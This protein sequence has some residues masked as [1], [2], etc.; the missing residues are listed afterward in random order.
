MN[1]MT[2]IAMSTILL[3]AAVLG[4]LLVIA[5][6]LKM[7]R[8]RFEVPFSMLWQ[9]VLKEKEA[10]SLWRHL[11][12]LLS[13][14][15]LVAMVAMLLF[16][17][18]DPM[19]GGPSES[20]R[21]VI[22]IIDSS[23]SMKTMDE[24]VDETDTTRL[25]AAKRKANEVLDSMGADDSVMIVR[26]DGRSTPMGRFQTDIPKLKRLVGQINATDT[27]AD[28]RSTLSTA[29]D[30]LRWRQNPV[31]IL[32]GD[33]AYPEE[34]LGSVVWENSQKK[35]TEAPAKEKAA[36]SGFE[37]QRLAIVDLSGIE[38]HY[39]PVGQHAENAGIVAFNVRRYISN[40]LNYEV[41]IEIQNFSDKPTTRRLVLYNG[42][43]EIDV[44][45][46][47]IPAGEKLTRIYPDLGGGEARVLR[48]RIETVDSAQNDIFPLDDQAFALI[49]ENKRQKI[50]L[51]SEDNLYLEGALLVFE[52]LDVDKLSPDEYE[53]QIAKSTL[54]EYDAAIFHDYTPEKLPQES[55]HLMYFRPQGEHSPFKTLAPLS[56]GRITS[57]STTH[58]VMRWI[59]MSDVNFDSLATFAID[60]SVGEVA[61]G[62]SLRS[63][64]A[65]AKKEGRRKIAAFGFSMTGTDLMLRTSFPLLMVNTLDWFAGA[66]SDLITTY[67]TGRRAR[68]P[69]DGT[70]G[71]SEVK[72]I[73]PSGKTYKAPLKEGYATFYA[74]EVGIYEL[75]A[76]KAELEVATI[77][78]AS[79]LSNPTES[80][81]QPSSE[82]ILGGKTLD[83]PKPG[84]S[85]YKQ[86]LWTYFVLMALLLLLVEWYTFNRRITV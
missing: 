81:I 33:G 27:P 43:S 26:M 35:S 49:P 3:L 66:D 10:R 46:I 73:S 58:P 63:V 15:L 65:A 5:Y 23:A 42:D 71:I 84:T 24:S 85:G 51:V 39:L 14:L 56:R 72:V 25:E 83:K 32:I 36:S 70:Y 4:G 30:A 20:A 16:A 75:V 50:L 9:R 11:K 1:L 12:R 37:D 68:V 47:K 60:R 55:T 54:L 69:L 74:S 38:V 62:L 59:E 41:Y 67:T 44:K 21:S 52:H 40:K 18:L 34:A 80:D 53:Q 22:I 79:N 86:S 6:I 28:L 19:L 7:K 78:L 77:S 76:S 48:A 29:S 17:A 57:V 64:I 45:E 2:P 82:L 13:L 31:I 8:R 61:L